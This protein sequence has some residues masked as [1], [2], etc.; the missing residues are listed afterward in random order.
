[1]A[2]IASEEQA[3]RVVEN[4]PDFEAPGG[5]L[6]STRVTGSQWDA[7]LVGRPLQLIAVQG[8]LRYGYE[9]DAKRLARNLY[10]C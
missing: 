4:L 6:T 7:P 8:L 2:G 3:K 5:L 10:L 9:E 1:V